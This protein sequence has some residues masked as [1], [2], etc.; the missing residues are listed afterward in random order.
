MM[1]AIHVYRK[2]RGGGSERKS[3]REKKREREREAGISHVVIQN[4]ATY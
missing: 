4:I 1:R 2:K 3:E